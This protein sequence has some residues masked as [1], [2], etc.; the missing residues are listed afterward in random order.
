M[1]NDA[2]SSGERRYLEEPVWR[3][4][5]CGEPITYCTQFCDDC[6]AD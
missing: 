4:E 2:Y 6:E 5:E 3:C 1:A